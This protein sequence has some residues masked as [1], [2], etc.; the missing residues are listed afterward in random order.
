MSHREHKIRGAANRQ[1]GE[2]PKNGSTAQDPVGKCFAPDRAPVMDTRLFPTEVFS[3]REIAQAAGVP[4]AEA[5]ALVASGAIPTVDGRLV[6]ADAALRAV[7]ILRGEDAGPT[8][9][10][11]LFHPAAQNRPRRSVPLTTAGLVHIGTF[12]VI[13]LT[14]MGTARPAE[15]RQAIDPARLVFLVRPGPGGGGGGGGLRQPAPPRQAMVK[16][17]SAPKLKSPVP[18]ERAVRREIEPPPRPRPTPPPEPKPVERPVEPPPPPAKP[19]PVPPVVAPVVSA[20]DDPRDQAGVLT[21]NR[22]PST[23]QGPG[24]GGGAGSGGGTG[25]GEGSGPGIGEGSG[26]G[27]GGGPYRPG[28]GI[29]APELLKEVRPEYT[30][31]ARRRSLSGDVLLEIVVRSDGR[32][33]SVRVLQGLGAGLDQR[34]VEAVRQWRF[35]PA[36]RLGTPVDVLVEVAVEFRL[37]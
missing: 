25:I 19:D 15:V 26:G 5:E 16:K 2:R 22:T 30:E 4:A 13:L 23:S 20:S 3:T 29:T 14:T 8:P 28:S 31:E 33:G 37:R 1:G 6:A 10:A 32:I 7:L 21:E 35:A 27:T 36:R 34:A 9:A 24:A 17:A 18:V 12:C 11:P